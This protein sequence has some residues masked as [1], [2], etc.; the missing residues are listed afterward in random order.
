[1]LCSFSAFLQVEKMTDIFIQYNL[2]FR[3]ESGFPHIM[4]FSLQPHRLKRSRLEQKG[5]NNV[6]R[7][8]FNLDKNA[9]SKNRR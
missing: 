3:E 8:S 4:T 2:K 6:S 5:E 1:M 9:C 7:T